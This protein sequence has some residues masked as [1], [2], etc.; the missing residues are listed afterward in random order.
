MGKTLNLPKNRATSN[1]QAIDVARRLI[2]EVGFEVVEGYTTPKATAKSAASFVRRHFG[3]NAAVS[4][5]G[6][7]VKLRRGGTEIFVRIATPSGQS[8]GRLRENEITRIQRD[9]G[10]NF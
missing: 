1:L 6:E 7:S 4:N 2:D 10:Y 5:T 3:I 9:T 8:A